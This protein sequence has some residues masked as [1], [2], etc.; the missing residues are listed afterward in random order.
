[1]LA[2]GIH[3]LWNGTCVV[4]TAVA[5]AWFQGWEV[6]LLGVSN[7][8]ALLALLAAQGMGLLV[9]LRALA[10]RL[11][12]ETGA[13]E[14]APSLALPTERAIAVWGLVCLTVLLPVG[15]GILQTV[16]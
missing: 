14:S 13:E 1:V 6:D 8:A 12:S 5:H 10:R 9:A 7:G 15:L 4:L 2:V 3:A 16:W 11:E